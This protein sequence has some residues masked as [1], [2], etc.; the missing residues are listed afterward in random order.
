MTAAV[1]KETFTPATQNRVFPA[2]KRFRRLCVKTK[3]QHG[4]GGMT[5]KN[6]N[7][8][9]A[10]WD[11]IREA[12]FN[13]GEKGQGASRKVCL[14][15]LASAFASEYRPERGDDLRGQSGDLLLNPAR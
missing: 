1:I 9:P 15:G 5:N 13:G 7:Q 4:E 10:G 14:R 8:K 6:G 11:D 12:T 2:S 3:R